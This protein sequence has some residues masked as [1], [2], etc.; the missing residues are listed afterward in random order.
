MQGQ[1]RHACNSAVMTLPYRAGPA[2]PGEQKMTHPE[3]LLKQVP[4]F[5][6]LRAE[7]S[8]HLAA[9]L[10]KQTLRKGDS[11]FREGEEGHSL[12][13]ITAGK[14]KILRQ[15]RDGD[16]VIL[17]VLSA[18][19]FCGEMALL[20]GLPRSA[21]AVAAEET[22]LYGLNRKDFIAYVMNNETAVKA[23]LATLS[24]RLRKADDFLEDVFFRNVAARLAKKLIELAGSNGCRIE[25]GGLIKLNVTQ[26]DLAGM[27]GATRESVNK[28]LRS[29]R[30]KN[31][32]ALSGNTIVIDDL[33]ALKQRIR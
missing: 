33:E 11:L 12:Y 18:G 6:F 23:I 15:S 2:G 10:Q 31:L 1:T 3:I 19:D 24:K 28:E 25:D 32:I 26:K 13:M 29:L 21:D 14:I 22:Q 4:L 17:A 20:D 16:E 8:R 7:D 9:L 5:R 30:E 27:I